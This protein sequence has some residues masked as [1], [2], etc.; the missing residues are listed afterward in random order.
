MALPDPRLVVAQLEASVV[1][2]LRPS[3]DTFE[4]LLGAH[5]TRENE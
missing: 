5:E 4:G 2:G 3:V 1:E